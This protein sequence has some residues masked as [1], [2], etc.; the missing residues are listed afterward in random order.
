MFLFDST[1]RP[2]S[3]WCKANNVDEKK[4]SSV[5][6]EIW[7]TNGQIKFRLWTDKEYYWK[8]SHFKIDLTL[9]RMTVKGMLLY[10]DKKKMK[11]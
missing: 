1:Y 7:T 2:Y 5:S 10:K 11:Q 4:K 8:Y 3:Q 6:R 9:N